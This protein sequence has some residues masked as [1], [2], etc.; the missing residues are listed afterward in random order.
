MI[1]KCSCLSQRKFRQ[2]AFLRGYLPVCEKAYYRVPCRRTRNT[3][4]GRQSLGFRCSTLASS[5]CHRK[6]HTYVSCGTLDQEHSQWFTFPGPRWVTPFCFALS[7]F[8]TNQGSTLVF[9]VKLNKKSGEESNTLR[10]PENG[11]AKPL[12]KQDLCKTRLPLGR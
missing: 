8:P 12:K 5:S 11:T 1:Y 3:A 2:I 6:S 7:V 9:M 4:R 10:A